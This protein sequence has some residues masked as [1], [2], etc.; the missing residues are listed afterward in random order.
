MVTKD[1]VMSVLDQLGYVCLPADI[2]F[3][4]L[5][6]PKV[7]EDIMAALNTSAVPEEMHHDYVLAVCGDLLNIRRASGQLNLS[8]LN[9][10]GI[11][12]ITEG[13]TTIVYSENASSEMRFAELTACLEGWQKKI[14][15]F[16][17]LV[18]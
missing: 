11:K 1:E 4:D 3:L 17:C 16:R 10:D 5:L 12:Q 18:W 7:G 8:A 2:D 15:R 14:P 6:I 9:F 13:D